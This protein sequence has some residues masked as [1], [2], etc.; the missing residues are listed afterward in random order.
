MNKREMVWKLFQQTDNLSLDKCR[1]IVEILEKEG[2]LPPPSMKT[3]LGQWDAD[4][5]DT[6][7]G[8]SK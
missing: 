6:K 8:R 3:T 2:M 4:L 1:K 5:L 7:Q